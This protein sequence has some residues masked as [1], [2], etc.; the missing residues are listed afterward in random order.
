MKGWTSPLIPALRSSVSS[1]SQCKSTALLWYP[2]FDS[3]GLR[4]RHETDSQRGVERMACLDL[5]T[6]NCQGIQLIC[7]FVN[8]LPIWLSV[9]IK[10]KP[11][12]VL[13]KSQQMKLKRNIPA[14]VKSLPYIWSATNQHSNPARQFSCSLPQ[15]LY[16]CSCTTASQC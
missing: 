12:I 3:A 10:S 1:H 16:L 8:Q 13:T 11:T 2:L 9:T 15:L 5:K 14:P 7:L 4:S 6:N